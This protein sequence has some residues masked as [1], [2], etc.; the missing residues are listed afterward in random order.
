[1]A[2]LPSANVT[3]SETTTAVVGGTDVVCVIAPVPANADNT[4]RL[5]GSAKA[6]RD[7][8]GYC[9]GVEYAAIHAAATQKPILFTGIAIATAG[10]V[11]R[12]DTSGNSG[13]SV[14][15]LAAGG[16]GVLTEHDGVLGVDTGGTIGTDQIV[17]TLSLDGGTTTKKVRLGT[18][19]SYEIPDVGVTVSFAA[20]TLVAGETI[21]TWHGTGPRSD[22]TG[23]A[24]ARA[25]LAAQQKA[26]R[27]GLLTGDLQNSTEAAALLAEV[28]AY[29]SENDRATFFRASVLD[30]L[31]LATLSALTHRMTG[32]PSIT[33]ETATDTITR[34]AGSFIADGFAVG[35]II[36]IA[37]STSNN[38]TL[39]AAITA[40]TATVLTTADNLT[41]EGPASGVTITGEAS[42]TFSD[43]TDT[44]TRSSGS[45][46]DDGFRVADSVTVA[47]SV[48]NDGT[49]TVSAVTATVLTVGAGDLSD[50]VIGATTPT[51][52]AGQT[53]AVW[54]AA[55]DAEFATIDDSPRISLGAG[56]A[57]IYSP[58][59]QWWYRR[60]V[61]WR[62]SIR[63]FQ[64][65]LQTTPWRKSDGPTGDLLTDAEGNLVEWDDYVDGAAGSA[66][67]FT[68]Y[69]TWA[70]GPVGVFI[71]L[72]LTRALDASNLIYTHNQAVVD[73]AVNLCQVA[74]EE[75]V[76]R[77]IVLND[78][79][80]ATKDS[81]ST[82]EMEVNSAL[83][84]ALL[85]DVKGEGPR[86]SKA[87]WTASRDDIL[88]VPE[89]VMTG[90]L[91]LNL[92][93]TIHT[94][95]TTVKVLSGGQ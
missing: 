88:N 51:I 41:D 40:V 64:H 72:S 74:T 20:G 32:A 46:L 71:A 21:H 77:S 57:R 34:S 10:V 3:V 76:G 30:R 53:K 70:N 85:T 42:L 9:E 52:S 24:A 87:V 8:H 36:T 48:A 44:I 68:T 82:I 69:R 95:N 37:G 90:V 22:S 80:T 83:D 39:T 84:L 13:T 16:S 92:L 43:A 45:W 6:I 61:T 86:A 89:A 94:I 81:L 60:P 4:P 58:L 65:D 50:E 55:I 28:N 25:A 62:D 79:G 59:T 47:S 66:A 63:A 18:A 91:E 26:F 31:P 15:S 19:S 78:D 27:S 75:V 56:R 2:T 93:G 23:W 7:Y 11:G 12:E 5:Y 73:L 67:R 1:M 49:F 29:K 54:M 35:D 14:S 33:F 17:L 38:G